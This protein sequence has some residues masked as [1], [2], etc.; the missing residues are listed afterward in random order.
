MPKPMSRA[1][2]EAFLREP[3]PAILSIPQEGKGPLS[4]PVWFDFEPGGDFW[5]VMQ[6]DSRKGRLMQVG[7]CVSLC[8]QLEARPYK[9]VTVEG[10]V[11]AV[12]PYDADTDLR[13][14]AARY[15]GDDEAAGFVEG[16]RD[17]VAKGNGIKV[18]FKPAR[19]LSADYEAT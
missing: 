1:A 10:P 13:A 5:I 14:M 8:V 3:R 6:K 4:S 11:T 19:W 9:Y 15:L 18:S 12:A 17:T 2:R 7:T 16:M